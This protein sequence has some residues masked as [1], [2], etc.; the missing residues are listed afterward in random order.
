MPYEVFTRE[1]FQALPVDEQERLI[2]KVPK[3]DEELFQ[4]LFVDKKSWC[5]DAP[6]ASDWVVETPNGHG[7]RWCSVC[8]R[9]LYTI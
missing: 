6:I 3:S 7:D 1:K 9:R 2:L 4:K 5:C 8:L